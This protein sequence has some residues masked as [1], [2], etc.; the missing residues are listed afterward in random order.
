M[1]MGN[2]QRVTYHF[3]SHPLFLIPRLTF[4]PLLFLE[5][6]VSLPSHLRIFPMRFLL[7]LASFFSSFNT[8]L[9]RSAM[10]PMD[11][12]VSEEGWENQAA[13]LCLSNF[14]FRVSADCCLV[15]SAP[16]SCL[17]SIRSIKASMDSPL[18]TFMAWIPS[19]GGSAPKIA[20]AHCLVLGA[21]RS[22]S[23]GQVLTS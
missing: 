2:N 7:L 22:S 8:H 21:A 4:L 10:R 14:L 13:S 16:S 12:H 9:V 11:T 6:E 18:A 23:Y 1:R 15:I 5:A 3:L 20:L 19:P 17:F